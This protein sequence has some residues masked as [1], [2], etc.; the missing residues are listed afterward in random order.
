MFR[1]KLIA[2]RQ[3]GQSVFQ[4]KSA[5]RRRT[6]LAQAKTRPWKEKS[7]NTPLGVYWHDINQPVSS[8]PV[9]PWRTPLNLPADSPAKRKAALCSP[10]PAPCPPVAFEAWI[11]LEY[12]PC[13]ICKWC[14]PFPLGPPRYWPWIVTPLYFLP[15]GGRWKIAALFHCPYCSTGYARCQ[16]HKIRKNK[17]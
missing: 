2:P 4:I 8:R 5:F 3:S 9:F 10:R 15:S 16:V 6:D 14:T 11:D 12:Y 7:W 1:A 13:V 17:D